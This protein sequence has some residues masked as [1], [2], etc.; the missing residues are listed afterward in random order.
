[1]SC[2]N[3]GKKLSPARKAWKGFTSTLQRKLH[4][5]KRSKAF[6]ITTSRI[7]SSLAAVLGRSPPF[8]SRLQHKRKGLGFTQAPTDL[9]VRIHHRKRRRIRQRFAPVYVDEL[10]VESLSVQAKAKSLDTP[11]AVTNK[12]IEK[13]A[14]SAAKS[15]P[16]SST[17]AV[18]MQQHTQL[19]I[20]LFDT[21]SSPE[22]S[23]AVEK[24]PAFA[25]G[26]APEASVAPA[27]T[28]LQG[29]DERAE[30]FITKF[31]AEMR[32]QRQR[33]F[34]EYQEMLARGC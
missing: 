13:C 34:G 8:S 33:S 30:E 29:V 28:K 26:H 31:R 32:L 3:L 18:T 22:T 24:D 4:K 20:K 9:R 6:K 17:R 10:F 14:A 15:Q 1:M 2:L 25:T 12:V 21:P 7:N 19:Q 11:S 16:E 27:E 23:T 5:L